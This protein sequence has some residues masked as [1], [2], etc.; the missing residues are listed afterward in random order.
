MKKPLL[1]ESQNE[2]QKKK[3]DFAFIKAHGNM[4]NY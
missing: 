3:N 2:K 1:E 4:K